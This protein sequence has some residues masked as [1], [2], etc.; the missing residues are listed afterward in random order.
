M[1]T[2]CNSFAL[3]RAIK[4]YSKRAYLSKDEAELHRFIEKFLKIA[5]TVLDDK[6]LYI[7]RRCIRSNSY[8]QKLFSLV[9]LGLYIRGK[10][11]AG[12]DYLEE[13]T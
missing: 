12:V 11:L 4:T 10:H 6:S 5:K 9:L 8:R 2:E 1:I 3:L 13:S 7:I